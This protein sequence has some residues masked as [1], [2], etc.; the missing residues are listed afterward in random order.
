[1]WSATPFDEFESAYKKEADFD[2]VDAWPLTNNTKNA[3][4]SRKVRHSRKVSV[5]G[6]CSRRVHLA[7]SKQ[8]PEFALEQGISRVRVHNGLLKALEYLTP[9]HDVVAATDIL[10]RNIDE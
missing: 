6:S 2:G 1:M 9:S 3:R 5:L 10:Q 8:N 7:N 4:S